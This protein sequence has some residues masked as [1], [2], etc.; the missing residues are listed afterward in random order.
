MPESDFLARF[1]VPELGLGALVPLRRSIFSW[2]DS[3]ARSIAVT[4]SSSFFIADAASPS[5]A[6][7]YRST[8]LSD[9][10]SSLSPIFI[11]PA[12]IRVKMV[13]PKSVSL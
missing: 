5:E 1:G 3:S 13:R 12:S 7:R 10:T 8:F 2:S 11:S 9:G 6:S 4:S